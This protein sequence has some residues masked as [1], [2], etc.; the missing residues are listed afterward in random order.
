MAKGTVFFIASLSF[1][2]LRYP[3]CLASI[4]N[5]QLSN[6]AN[7]ILTAPSKWQ[8]DV[9]EDLCPNRGSRSVT[10]KTGT[11]AFISSHRRMVMGLSSSSAAQ[12][13]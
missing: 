11:T 3:Q 1:A 12:S 13:Q 5:T 6:N 9:S 10:F 7:A 8:K 2:R 4:V